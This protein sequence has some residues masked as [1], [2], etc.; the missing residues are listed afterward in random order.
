MY[1]DDDNSHMY[2]RVEGLPNKDEPSPTCMKVFKLQMAKAFENIS[3][4]SYHLL[5]MYGPGKR[6][7]LLTLHIT[8][9][10]GCSVKNQ[11]FQ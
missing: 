1:Y 5:I 2:G 9:L 4:F 7:H 3:V 10:K 8:H 6:N 11:L